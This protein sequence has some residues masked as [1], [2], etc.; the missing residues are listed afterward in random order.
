[1]FGDGVRLHAF[2]FLGHMDICT[3][4]NTIWKSSHAGKSCWVSPEGFQGPLC[5][6]LCNSL[7]PAHCWRLLVDRLY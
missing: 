1:M 4:T 5:A 6:V 3:N 2:L 7:R